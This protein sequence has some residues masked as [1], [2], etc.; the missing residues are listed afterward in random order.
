MKV[1]FRVDSSTDISSGHIM[2]CLAL[3]GE[4]KKQE[5]IDIKFVSRKFEGNLNDLVTKRGFKIVQ[6]KKPV[7][8][9]MKSEKRYTHTKG[10]K[11]I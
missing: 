9:R 2:R 8:I 3:A 11:K 4:M 10:T 5:S 7:M 1:I 6:L